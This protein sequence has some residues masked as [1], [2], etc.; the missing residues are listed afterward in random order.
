MVY[1]FDRRTFVKTASSLVLG[2]AVGGSGP[3]IN[4]Y[5][6]AHARTLPPQRVPGLWSYRRRHD[7]RGAAARRTGARGATRD[8]RLDP[9]ALICRQP[10]IQGRAAGRRIA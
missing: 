5:R 3:H 8:D 6:T 10:G 4:T 9:S 1:R 7:P 2:V